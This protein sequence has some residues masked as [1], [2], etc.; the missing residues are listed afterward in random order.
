MTSFFDL[1]DSKKKNLSI[2]E[3]HNYAERLEINVYKTSEKTG[4]KIKKTKND[5]IDELDNVQLMNKIQK[6]K[7]NKKTKSSKNNDKYIPN[8]I[9]WLEDE[10]EKFSNQE[11]KS[12]MLNYIYV[13]DKFKIKCNFGSIIYYG[14]YYLVNKEHEFILLELVDYEITQKDED[15]LI[16][17]LEFTKNLN[18]PIGFFE[19]L[20]DIRI[21]IGKIELNKKHSYVIDKLNLEE[22]DELN[23]INFNYTYSFKDNKFNFE[24]ELN[25]LGHK[26]IF[27]NKYPKY[28]FFPKDNI[29]LIQLIDF[30]NKLSNHQFLFNFK[31]YGPP[32]VDLEPKWCESLLI[33]DLNK[34]FGSKKKEE[35]SVYD[36][37]VYTT[38]YSKYKNKETIYEQYKEELN[39]NDDSISLMLKDNNFLTFIDKD[40]FKNFIYE[41]GDIIME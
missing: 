14:D 20:N 32:E 30:H 2:P 36:C 4:K 9:L 5:L 41:N 34:T 28:C 23:G 29:S 35:D 21:H 6:M 13:Q 10:K 39:S 11:Y 25:Y 8:I 12:N 31:L 24:I 19:K 15:Y 26:G 22:E 38:M 17:P 7:T 37:I 16:I 3:L 40:E 27:N 18:N 33:K 1:S